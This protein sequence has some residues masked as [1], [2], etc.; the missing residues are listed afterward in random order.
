MIILYD[1]NDVSGQSTGGLIGDSCKKI[2]VLQYCD[3]THG[4]ERK[5]RYRGWAWAIFIGVPVL[6]VLIIAALVI[7]CIRKKSTTA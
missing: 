7:Y 1:V 5:C 3:T 4:L 6:A 2:S